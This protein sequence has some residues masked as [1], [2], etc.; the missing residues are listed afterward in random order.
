MTQ[1]DLP[2]GLD[3]EERRLLDGYREAAGPSSAQANQLWSRL[4]TPAPAPIAPASTTLR[5]VLGAA[6]LA[7]ATTIGLSLVDRGGPPSPPVT[8]TRGESNHDARVSSVAP[9]I[10]PAMTQPA[11][12]EQPSAVEPTHVAPTRATTRVERPVRGG[13]T[14][15]LAL[16]ERARI[17]IGRGDHDGALAALAEHER[18]FARGE[19]GEERRALRVLA[20]CSGGNTA[21]GRAEARSF[22]VDH[23]SAALAA[24]IRTACELGD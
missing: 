8:A 21:Q 7:G 12:T 10:P 18:S 5:L 3:E 6:L 20:L 24:R 1:R 11:S 19:L 4:A 17:A 23:P 13:L 15:E 16:L 22:L 9:A 2:D 14:E